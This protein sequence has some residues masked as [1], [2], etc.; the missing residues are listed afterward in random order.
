MKRIIDFVKRLRFAWYVINNHK[1]YYIIFGDKDAP[2]D[3]VF[4]KAA[5]DAA[6]KYLKIKTDS[7]AS[8]VARRNII[9]QALVTEGSILAQYKECNECCVSYDC[10]SDEDLDE[11]LN[12]EI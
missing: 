10:N 8:L 4:L 12:Q 1:G 5:M 7:Q 2:D 9:R 6:E 11:F 3:Y